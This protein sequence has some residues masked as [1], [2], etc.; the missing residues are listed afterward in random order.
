MCNFPCANQAKSKTLLGPSPVLWHINY[1]CRKGG[2][3]DL[4]SSKCRKIQYKH[5]WSSCKF[6]VL[7]QRTPIFFESCKVFDQQQSIYSLLQIYL[8]HSETMVERLAIYE[9]PKMTLQLLLQHCK[10]SFEIKHS[11]QIC[12]ISQA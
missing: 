4:L 8:H 3:S 10:Y 6:Y 7:C 2:F 9:S 1:F 5:I 11:C 12:L